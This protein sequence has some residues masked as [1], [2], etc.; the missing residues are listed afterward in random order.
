MSVNEWPEITRPTRK[1]RNKCAI[2]SSEVAAY[3]E[4][5][6]GADAFAA[7]YPACFR[8]CVTADYRL[9][10]AYKFAA[11]EYACVKCRDNTKYRTHETHNE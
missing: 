10:G 1:L 4:A 3:I 9:S 11:S 5:A 8:Y 2:H 7:P 6:R